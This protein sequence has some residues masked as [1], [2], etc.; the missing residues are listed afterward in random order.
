M[1]EDID[2]GEIEIDLGTPVG[3]HVQNSL[4]MMRRLSIPPEWSNYFGVERGDK[5][6]LLCKEAS[7]EVFWDIDCF[8]E[9]KEELEDG[10]R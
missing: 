3:D 1:N 9:A 7:V 6:Y 10:H 4:Q 8:I 2:T 5:A